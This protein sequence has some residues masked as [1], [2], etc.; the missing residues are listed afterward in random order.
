MTEPLRLILLAPGGED[1]LAAER[2]TQLLDTDAVEFEAVFWQPGPQVDAARKRGSVGVV[3]DL[4]ARSATGVIERAL[5]RL[6]RR[7][8]GHALRRRRLGLT[9]P[10]RRAVDAVFLT[11]PRAAP[12]LRYLPEP[13]PATVTTLVPTGEMCDANREPLNDQDRELLLARTSRFLVEAES[14]QDRLIALGVPI[15]QIVRIGEIRHEQFPPTPAADRIAAVRRGLGIA[16]ATRVVVGSGPVVWDG[17][18]DLF[19]RTGWILRERLGHEVALCW[20]GSGVDELERNQLDHDIVHMGLADHVHLATDED[21]LALADVH[22][23]LARRE[24]EREAYGVPASRA[25]A[26]VGFHTPDLDRFVGADAGIVVDFLDLEGVANAIAS[27]LDDDARR[28]SLASAAARRYGRWHVS[29][30][31]GAFLLELLREA[32]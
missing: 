2:L 9:P 4:T 30:E 32:P 6:G 18:T 27:L 23:L 11:S 7:S 12:M 26:I 14:S 1:D 22:V 10:A 28:A 16:P 13:A 20:V 3:T 17:G 19:V 25:Q 5:H 24:D 21:V 15:E 29:A 31:R 8:A